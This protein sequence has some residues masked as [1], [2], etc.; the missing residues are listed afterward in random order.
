[1]NFVFEIA[2]IFSLEPA[3]KIDWVRYTPMYHIVPDI[4]RRKLTRF[5]P[6]WRTVNR[7]ITSPYVRDR[8]APGFLIIRANRATCTAI[9]RGIGENVSK[10][11]CIV[12]ETHL[13]P[14]FRASSRTP[15]ALTET[16]VDVSAVV[17]RGCISSCDVL[18]PSKDQTRSSGFVL[19]YYRRN[20]A[21]S[22]VADHLGLA[23]P[24]IGCRLREV[25]TESSRFV[26]ANG[27]AVRSF[28]AGNTNVGK[29]RW[30]FFTY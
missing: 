11:Y 20:A 9:V 16:L 26:K 6:G 17:C 30:T 13:T 3:R 22:S 4:R 1:M 10:P 18:L 28:G 24:W 2:P 15:Q 23:E 29:I 7:F 5:S 19:N 14:L 21:V 25:D 12:H 8:F 27:Q